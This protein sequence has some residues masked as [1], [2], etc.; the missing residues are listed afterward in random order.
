MIQA[1]HLG[2]DARATYAASDSGE[3]VLGVVLSDN[4]GKLLVLRRRAPG[5]YGL[6]SE[7]SAFD[8]NF[9]PG[10]DIEIVRASGLRRF[11]IQ[12]NSHSGCG[13]QVETFRVALAGGAWRVAGYDKSEPDSAVTCDVNF[14]SREYSANLLT[15]R[16]HVVEYRAGNEVGRRSRRTGISAPGLTSFSFSMFETEP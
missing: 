12:V 14:R 11:L 6:E 15:G 9:G 1:A 8:N 5:N 10:Y 16:V 3:F 7:S 4:L 2:P 13:I